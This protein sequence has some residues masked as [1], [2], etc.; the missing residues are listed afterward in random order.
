M[1]TRP[2]QDGDEH[3]ITTLFL[4]SDPRH[5]R[6]VQYWNWSNSQRWN[7][8]YLSQVSE[9]QNRIIGHYAFAGVPVYYK[10]RRLR[11]ASS[12]QA[13]IHKNHRDLSTLVTLYQE[14]EKRAAQRYD[15]VFGFPNDHIFPIKTTLFQWV[16]IAEFQ[17][18]EIPVTALPKTGK[19]PLKIREI[20]SFP[21]DFTAP[22]PEDKFHVLRSADFLNW[23]FFNHPINHYTLLGAYHGETLVGYLVLK[24][25]MPRDG[26]GP[27]GHFID[28]AARRGD[29]S[30]LS[31]LLAE[32]RRFF[33]FNGIQTILFWNRLHP[34]VE[35]MGALCNGNR[36]FSTHLG[37]RNFNPELAPAATALGNWS[38]SMA[39][40][41]AF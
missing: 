40:S 4:S 35:F 17:A 16:E 24:L 27:V 25:Y 14:I 1:E 29:T 34:Y 11:V 28:Y 15:F 13:V 23:R 32:A 41:D 10:N 39:D 7:Q 22:G 6:S 20:H 36:G 19:A 38:F 37:I 30:I 5:S 9:S 33:Q 12:Q 8:D 21:V 2:Y 31:P 18:H 3:G 26:S